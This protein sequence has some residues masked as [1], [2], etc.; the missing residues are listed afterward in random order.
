MD[1][2]STLPCIKKFCHQL[3]HRIK[4]CYDGPECVKNISTWSVCANCAMFYYSLTVPI[5]CISS[6]I[7]V[8]RNV[9]LHWSQIG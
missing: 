7:G 3:L 8:Y 6:G 2:C 1:V 5:E 9:R 4:V